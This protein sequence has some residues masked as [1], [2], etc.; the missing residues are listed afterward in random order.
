MRGPGSTRRSSQSWRKKRVL[1]YPG[2]EVLLGRHQP[3]VAASRERQDGD[4]RHSL[5]A[6]AQALDIQPLGV[7][8]R[9]QRRWRQG[10]TLEDGS[11]L[12]GPGA[13]GNGRER[14]GE[15]VPGSF[16]G[17]EERKYPLMEIA[18]DLAQSQ[19]VR[20]RVMG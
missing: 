17:E 5:P 6:V 14:G 15:V 18:A 19:Q 8:G 10:L 1:L 3:A 4:H 12:A 13:D 2:A 7:E 11:R 16:A 9:K 20:Q